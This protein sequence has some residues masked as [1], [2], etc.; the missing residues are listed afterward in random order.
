MILKEGYPF[1]AGSLFVAV[2]LVVIFGSAGWLTLILPLYTA[3]FFRN[4]KR[5]IPTEKNLI[6]APADG[7][8]L[9]VGEE[10]E[11]RYLQKKVK[12]VSIFMS[13]MDV[14][15]NRV[16]YSGKIKK[17]FYN[18]GKYLAAFK[19]KAS[20]DNEQNAVLLETERGE[21]ILFVQ[22]AGWLARRIVCYLKGGESVER[23]ARY[24]LIRFGSRMD[25]YLPS[26]AELLVSAGERAKAGETAIAR[27]L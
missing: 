3:Y 4:P 8:I 18:H 6:L 17:V 2:L 13:P 25:V 7:K 1:V 21:E 20:L 11:T 10:E 14:H 26:T 19:E 27:F 5:I 15:V 12:K 24:G 9:T 23:G 16:P 22:I